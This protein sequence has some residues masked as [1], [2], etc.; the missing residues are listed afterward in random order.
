VVAAPAPGEPMDINTAV[1]LVLKKS[2]A[3]DGLSRGLHEAARAIERVSG[4]TAAATQHAAALERCGVCW[5]QAFGATQ[6]PEVTAT[7]SIISAFDKR[8]VLSV[9]LASSRDT[10]VC[11]CCALTL[12]L[13]PLL[14]SP[15]PPT[16]LQGEAQ[17]CI[18]AEDC[19]QPDY[20]KLIEALCGEHNVNLIRCATPAAAAAA[21]GTPDVS[22]VDGLAAAAAGTACHISYGVLLWGALG[23]VMHTIALFQCLRSLWVTWCVGCWALW[24]AERT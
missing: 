17:L 19:N 1:Q 5:S 9:A 8:P 22:V 15:P 21:G 16:H 10:A 20:K 7:C 18:L 6:S 23:W 2:L 13:C 14:P 4:T 12:S 3:H 24:A 11:I